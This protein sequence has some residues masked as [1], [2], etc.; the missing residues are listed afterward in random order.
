MTKTSQEPNYV[1]MNQHSCFKGF[2]AFYVTG[3][4]LDSSDAR[5]V[6]PTF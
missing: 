3:R 2:T 6:E 5:Q 1:A 4:K